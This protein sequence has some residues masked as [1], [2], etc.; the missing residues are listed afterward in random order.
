MTVVGGGEYICAAY[1][2]LIRNSLCSVVVTGKVVGGGVPI[3]VNVVI[4]SSLIL[5]RHR[6]GSNAEVKKRFSGCMVKCCSNTD[7]NGELCTHLMP[8]WD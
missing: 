7:L 2:I 3:I 4:A 8:T 5:W 6:R 1:D